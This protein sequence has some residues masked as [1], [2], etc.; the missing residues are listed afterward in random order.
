MPMRE[1]IPARIP[2]SIGKHLFEHP[3]MV[4]GEAINSLARVFVG[5][6]NNRRLSS[7]D[8]SLRRR[9][10]DRSRARLTARLWPFGLNGEC[11]LARW[12]QGRE[13][14]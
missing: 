10:L 3:L 1:Y 2:R 7:H 5:R 6:P 12:R 9:M 8:F 13:N 4:R 14:V 11:G